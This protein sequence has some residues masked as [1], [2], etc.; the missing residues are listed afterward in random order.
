M[1]RVVLIFGSSWMAQAGKTQMSWT[2]PA[3]SRKARGLRSRGTG[4]RVARSPV[5]RMTT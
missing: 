1:R 5:Q 4:F 3:L 2:R